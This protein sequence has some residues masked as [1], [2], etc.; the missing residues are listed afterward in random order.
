MSSLLIKGAR[1]LVTMD[2]ERR[3]FTDGA[4]YIENDRIVAVG[5][6]DTV[7]AG[8]AADRV[9]DARHLLVLPGLINAHTHN[10]NCLGRGLMAE[11]HAKRGL[12]ERIFPYEAALDP[13]AAYWSAYAAQAEMI[14]R[15]IT[16][17]VD[18]GTYFPDEV[19][20]VT[21]EVGMR[22]VICR[23]AADVHNTG[24]GE[25]PQNYM[26]RETLE[27]AVVRSEDTV[28][29]WHG[30]LDG[31]ARAF[32]CV[33]FLQAA[34]DDLVRE[35]K[36]Q[37]RRFGVGFETHAAHTKDG[38]DATLQRHGMRDVQR[39]HHL[40]ALDDRTVLVHMIWLSPDEQLLLAE[41]QVNVAFCPAADLH[42]AYAGSLLGRYPELI[43]LGVNVVLGTD[44]GIGGRFMDL[45]RDL[46]LMLN[47]YRDTRLDP[48]VL[49]PERVLEMVTLGAA[50]A[51]G[52]DDEIGVV[53]SGMKADLALFDTR[54]PA[55][56]PVHNPINN[57]VQSAVG[58]HADTVIVDG[59]ILMEGK[60]VKSFNYPERARQIQAASDALLERSDMARF[61]TPRWPLV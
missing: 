53:A 25:F 43:D 15:G 8:R 39:L 27:Q 54:E 3:I 31:R 22:G 33:R 51:A 10:T 36:A 30:K 7:A 61:M 60:E 35:M 49:S 37:A 42:S 19:M 47:I 21:A 6:T 5:K 12:F 32:C 56:V 52:W 9:I 13:D 38:L 55:W 40:G 57:F 18:A 4:V 48:A 50:R 41:H 29:R 23:S 2:P 44:G 45:V 14:R 20:A 16:T 28:R 46:H 59:R 17:Y 24:M 11:V 58:A 34:T 26:G 1:W